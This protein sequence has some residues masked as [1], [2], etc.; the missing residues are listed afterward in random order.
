M[1]L[2]DFGF[3]TQVTGPQ[4]FL[5]T[6]CGSPPYSSPEL[7]NDDQYVGGPCDIWALGVL[8][9]FILIGNMPF[10]APSVPQL[11]SSILKGEYRLPGHFTPQCIKLIRKL[12]LIENL[13]QSLKSFYLQ[14]AFYSTILYID[15]QSIRLFAVNGCSNAQNG[16]NH[17]FMKLELLFKKEKELLS[18]AQN[19]AKHR[20]YLQTNRK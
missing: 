10:S 15:Q 8:L 1:K 14:S 2:G 7:F 9:F 19:H 4:H 5:N 12:Y 3:S 16:H 11:R 18:G 17:H 6:F 13:Q 20:R